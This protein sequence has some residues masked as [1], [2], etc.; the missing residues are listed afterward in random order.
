MQVFNNRTFLTILAGVMFAITA[1]AQVTVK[2]SVASPTP[3]SPYIYGRNGSLSG[4]SNAP[5]SAGD[6]TRL[7]DSG[8][9]FLRESGGNNSTKYNWRLRMSSHPDWYNNV[10]PNNWDYAASTLQQRLPAAQGMWSFQLIG[11][12]AKSNANN[13]NDWGYNQSQWW[14]GVNQN[15]AGGGTVE[16][17]GG[18]KAKVEGNPNLYLQNWTADSTV[19]LLDHWFG[20]NGI[21]LR[22][23]TIRYWSMDNE[24]EIWNGTHDDVMPTQLSAEDFMQRYFEVAKRARA[25]YPNI[26]LLG[27]VPANEWQWFNWDG[28]LVSSGGKSYPWLEYFIKR[29]AEEQQATG[30]R[31]LDVLDVHFYPGSSEPDK[32]VQMHRVFFDKTYSFP[33]ANGLKKIN[34]GWDNN[35]TQE[36]LFERCKTWLQTY[37]GPDHG[38]TFGVSETGVNNTSPN[39]VAVWYAS[40]MGEFMKHPEV[41]VFTPWT[42][43]KG[44]WE[45]LHL[46][47]R[48]NQQQY[49]SATSS[50][51]DVVSAYP[52]LSLDGDSLSVML[53]NRSTTATKTVTLQLTDFILDQQNYTLYR[54]NNLPATETF[55][56]HTNNALQKS[57]VTPSGNGFS[58]SLP[59]LSISALQVTGKAGTV[60]AVSRDVE[61]HIHVYPN[62][63]KGTGAWV[64]VTTG[65][66]I[67]LYLEDAQGRNVQTLYDGRPDQWPW[68]KLVDLAPFAP[69]VYILKV[70]VD[71]TTAVRK[72]FRQ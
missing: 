32:I 66:T 37:M 46:F 42:W 27:P 17:S 41:E 24:P 10:Y 11:K 50:S 23:E 49:V 15:L 13:F 47:A 2:V 34:G 43:N 12:A 61:N 22:K 63:V 26:K 69:G 36:Y 6:W 54:L 29:V 58:L 31:L 25:K 21:G 35:L 30:I 56:S 4:D 19:A 55:V 38:V 5:L 48:Y 18:S 67:S 52:S 39:V 9:R 51:E 45:T 1:Q 57:T 7:Q 44:M 70:K 16:P 72:V 20:A 40:T 71:G 28:N 3:I 60:T 53:V 14:E 65:T 33:D 59:P 68:K 8:I 64:E 62:P